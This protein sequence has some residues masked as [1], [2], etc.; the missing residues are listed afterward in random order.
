MRAFRPAASAARAALAALVGLAPACRGGRGAPAAAATSGDAAR[1]AGGPLPVPGD[2]FEDATAATGVVFTDVLGAERF[3]GGG[4]A[5]L[6]ADGDGDPDLFVAGDE[7]P[8]TFWRNRGDGTFDSA[9]AAAGL[10]GVDRAL[11]AAVADVD[12]DGDPDLYVL[13]AGPDRLYVND[14]SGAFGDQ[15]A[16]RGLGDDAVGTAAAFGDYDGDGWLDL[17]VGTYLDPAAAALPYPDRYRGSP[18]RLY[19]GTGGGTFAEVAAAPGRVPDPTLA[20]AWT[21]YDGDGDVD[22]W[23]VND[24]GPFWQP[25]R[26]WRNDGGGAF[27]EVS[28]A[29]GAGARVF[30]MGVSPAD[31]DADGDLDFYVTN[32]M[33]NVLHVQGPGGAFSDGAAAAGIEVHGFLDPAQGAPVYPVYDPAGAPDEAAMAAFMAAYAHPETG[34]WG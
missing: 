29:L 30:G 13:R 19:R 9:A 25:D 1:D 16:A 14:G 26:L 6:D 15:T 17:Y 22:L 20:A 10:A 33:A 12:N 34:E 4:V 7:L 28:A 24:F 23:V 11:G 31:V 21:D 8:S 3:V 32:L 18:N 27:T 2:P 5:F